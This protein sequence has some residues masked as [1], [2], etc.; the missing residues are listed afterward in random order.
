MSCADDCLPCL[1]HVL[2]A[3][4]NRVPSLSHAGRAG[5]VDAM[6]QA[7]IDPIELRRFA[8]ELKR[9][10][11]DTQ[12]R[13]MSLQARFKALGDTWQDEEHLRFSEE[14]QRTLRALGKFVEVSHQHVPFLLRKARRIEEY[15][16][17]R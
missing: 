7:I 3:T 2:W 8:E 10:N 9:F 17:Q 6:S 16:A 13:L 1:A 11:Q 15:L 12:D 14:F 5:W 4:P